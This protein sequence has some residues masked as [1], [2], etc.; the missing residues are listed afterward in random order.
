MAD[1]QP[2]TYYAICTTHRTGSGLLGEALWRT[3]MAGE[4]DEYFSEGVEKRYAAQWGTSSTSDYLD[5]V[6]ARTASANGVCGFKV[7]RGH[8]ETFGTRFA[9]GRHGFD[10]LESVFPNLHYVWLKR[11][12][13]IRQAISVWKLQQTGVSSWHEDEPPPDVPLPEFDFDAVDAHVRRLT[14]WDQRWERDFALRALAPLSLVYEDDLD[15]DCTDAVRKTLVHIGVAVPEEFS[16]DVSR[17]TQRDE[18]SEAFVRLYRLRAK[19][20]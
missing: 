12:D 5:A 9:N 1:H 8:L 17:R 14:E 19:K 16:V 11:R 4:P 15:A 18:L 10:A 2:R 3:G 6:R 20:T 13:K 7:M